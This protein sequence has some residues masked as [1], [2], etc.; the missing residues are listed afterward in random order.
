MMQVLRGISITWCGQELK[1]ALFVLGLE[2]IVTAYGNVN[3][4]FHT[5]TLQASESET[6]TIYRQ[7]TFTPRTDKD[8][9][10]NDNPGSRRWNNRVVSRAREV[11]CQWTATTREPHHTIAVTLRMTSPHKINGGLHSG[12]CWTVYDGDSKSSTWLGEACEGGRF[13]EKK[14][15]SS[16]KSLFLVFTQGAKTGFRSFQFKYKSI[17]HVDDVIKKTAVI[18]SAVV[19][20]AGVVFLALRLTHCC[21]SCRQRWCPQCSDKRREEDEEEGGGGGRLSAAPQR[22]LVCLNPQIRNENEVGRLVAP[23]EGEGGPLPPLPLPSGI[24]QPPPAYEDL[25]GNGENPKI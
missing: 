16:G 21:R 3:C 13:S 2:L 11:V 18:S 17:S 10:D 8:D 24:S 15:E 5:S 12:D 19:A 25:F 9:G 23:S 6:N 20:S 14:F 22:E 4:P 1:T 7:Y